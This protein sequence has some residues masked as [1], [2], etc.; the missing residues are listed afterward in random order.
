MGNSPATVAKCEVERVGL[1]GLARLRDETVRV[2]LH[3]ILVDFGVMHE[4]PV[5]SRE[6]TR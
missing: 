5:C 3:G 4:V 6:Q 1:R 2:K